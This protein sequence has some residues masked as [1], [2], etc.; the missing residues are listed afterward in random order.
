[1]PSRSTRRSLS[2]VLIVLALAAFGLV[3]TPAPAGAAPAV[4]VISQVYGGGG[5]TGAPFANDYVELFNRGTTTVS[6]AGWS[7]QYTSATGTGNLGAN[8]AQLTELPAL[9]LAPGQYVLVQ[10]AA[11]AGVGSPLPTPDVTDATPINM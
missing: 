6:T 11:G 8:S 9:S 3:G 5:H 10:Q 1:M 7:I 2:T 4:V